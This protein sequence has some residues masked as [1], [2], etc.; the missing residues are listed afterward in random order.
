MIKGTT[1]MLKATI[2]L[3]LKREEDTIELSSKKSNVEIEGL[4]NKSAKHLNG[5]DTVERR[6]AWTSIMKILAL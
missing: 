5:R 1:E 6:R 3:P 2:E 4:L